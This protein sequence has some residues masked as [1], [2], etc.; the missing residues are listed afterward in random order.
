MIS[1]VLFPVAIVLNSW[2]V[3]LLL[4][5]T[6]RNSRM[7]ALVSSLREHETRLLNALRRILIP[8]SNGKQG[9]LQLQTYYDAADFGDFL[10]VCLGA[11]HT[12]P[13]AFSEASQ[14]L[15]GTEMAKDANEALR[16]YNSGCSFAVAL[17]TAKL[18]SHLE[19]FQN[20]ADTLI[21]GLKM[22]SNLADSIDVMCANL[23]KTASSKVEESAARAPVKMLFP[24]VCFIF[25]A[26]FILLGAPVI[27]DL[28]D[29]MN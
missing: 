22:G 6:H 8:G 27:R 4:K 1:I 12:I 3:A 2:A 18:N 23:R 16:F 25:P 15:N 7:L 28:M 21:V 14:C 11:G 20:L 10:V 19:A 24:M 13:Q 26:I 17:E 5:S 9:R 29:A